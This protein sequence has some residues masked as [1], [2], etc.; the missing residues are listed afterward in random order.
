MFS[1]NLNSTNTFDN[2]YRFEEYSFIKSVVKQERVI[3]VGL[4]PF[5]AVM[6]DIKVIDGYHTIYSMDYKKRF[7]EIIADELEAND[8]LRKYYDNWG[9]RVYAFYNDSNKLLIN[10]KAAKSV[11]ANY[12]I[13]AFPIKNVELE[14]ICENCRDNKDIFLYKIL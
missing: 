11:G 8:W 4:D 1:H 3:S 14:S 6:S 7:R 12:V 10:F 2:Y 9:N 13:S 5:I